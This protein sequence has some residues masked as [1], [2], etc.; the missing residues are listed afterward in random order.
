[1]STRSKLLKPVLVL[2]GV[3]V[4]ATMAVPATAAPPT[5]LGKSTAA[6]SSSVRLLKITKPTGVVAGDVL[7]AAID[8]GLPSAIGDH[9]ACGLEPRARRHQH[10]VARHDAR[11]ST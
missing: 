3:I 10:H 1:M 7:L 2:V 5:L 8:V 4:A 6:S 9:E 11:R